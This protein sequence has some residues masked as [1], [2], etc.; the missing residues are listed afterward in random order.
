[1]LHI[2]SCWAHGLLRLCD[3]RCGPKLYVLV[4]VHIDSITSS[5]LS[6]ATS[7]NWRVIDWL[8]LLRIR[9]WTEINSIFGCGVIC[10]PHPYIWHFFLCQIGIE[11]IQTARQNACGF[12]GHKY[13]S[14]H[15]D[16]LKWDDRWPVV[17][18]GR[19]W[20]SMV[21]RDPK[22]ELCWILFFNA[23]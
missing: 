17:F 5:I 16:D 2:C 11:T 6:P 3:N 7:N 21:R 8:N 9:M 1:M 13:F 12:L 10:T 15:K 23:S 22:I 19:R 20:W 18:D 14:R 4:C